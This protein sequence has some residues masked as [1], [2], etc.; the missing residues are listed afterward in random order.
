MFRTPDPIY[1]V[2]ALKAVSELRQIAELNGKASGELGGTKKQDGSKHLHLHE[3]LEH[4]RDLAFKL[5]P[6]DD[7]DEVSPNTKVH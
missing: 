4:I 2:T 6:G 1:C 7:D 3:S 5:L